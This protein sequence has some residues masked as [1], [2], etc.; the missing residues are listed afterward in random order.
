MKAEMKFPCALAALAFG[1]AAFADAPVVEPTAD[2]FYDDFESGSVDSG[3]WYAAKT[4]FDSWHQYYSGG[5]VPDN[6]YVRDGRLFCEVH[7]DLY[8]GS[9]L[10][11]DENG[12]ARKNGT[13]AG[14]CAVT[15]GHFA[16][17]SYEIRAK[18][19]P[20]LGVCSA[21]W[22]T[23]AVSN[24]VREVAFR[25]PGHPA[26]DSEDIGFGHA[27][28]TTA[29]GEKNYE[30]K[31]SFAELPAA[32]DDGAFHVYRF[33]WHTGDPGRGVAQR[34]EFYVD[35]VLVQT[36]SDKV[37]TRAS[38]F[39]IGAWFPKDWA[40]VPDFDTYALEIDYVKIVP[41]HEAGDEEAAD[42]EQDGSLVDPLDVVRPALWEVGSPVAR[43][44]VA[45]LEEGG[46]LVISGKGAVTNFE[47]AADAPWAAEADGITSL[48]VR[49]GISEVGERSLSGLDSLVELNGTRLDLYRQARSAL[50]KEDV[51]PCEN[52]AITVYRSENLVDWTPVEDGISLG[53]DGKSVRIP[54]LSGANRGFFK[55]E[56]K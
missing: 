31:K 23:T 43:D 47:S 46:V 4:N 14:A 3:R 40:G 33:D 12:A 1:C 41:F 39:W 53:A 42:E 29:L 51:S 19:A 32:Q 44:V 9:I 5:V 54:I 52:L 50:G 38:R 28:C 8:D 6:L 30:F 36:N 16:S 13:R 27:I 22:S 10:G 24:K 21:M 49:D 26:S 2:M 7:G 55:F 17:G 45:R 48:V 35:G 25:M 37:P 15:R 20:V 56:A 18:V 34:V 11:I